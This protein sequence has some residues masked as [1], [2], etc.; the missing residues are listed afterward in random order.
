MPEDPDFVLVRHDGLVST[1]I[2]G[3][4]PD[5]LK[6]SRN[7]PGKLEGPLNNAYQVD[8]WLLTDLNAA[9]WEQVAADVASRLTDDV[10]EQAVRAL[11]QRWF[12][13]SGQQ[14][15]ADLKAR[16]AGLVAYVMRVYRLEAKDV[17]VHATDRD[18]LVT[19]LRA[20]DNSVDVTM[21]VAGD[22]T[23]YFRRRFLASET[24]EIRIYLHGGNDRVARTGPA[25]GPIL[26]RVIAGGGNDVIDDSQS[27]GT[28][29]WKDAGTVDMMRGAGSKVRGDVWVNPEPIKGAPWIEPRSFG[30]FTV[31][32]AIIGYNPDAGALLGYGFTRTAWGFRT[33]NAASSEQTI[34]GAFATSDVSGRVDYSGT[35]RRPASNVAFR[36]EA[37]GSGIERANFFGYG[38]D[39]PNETDRGRYRTQQ[40]VFSAAPS[41][42]IEQGRRFEAFVTPE[43]K[44]TRRRMRDP[45]RFSARPIPSV[46]ATS[47]NSRSGA[48]CGSIPGSVPRCMPPRI[49]P[50]ACRS[51]TRARTSRAS[52]SRRRV[53]SS[54]RRGTW[55]SQYGGFDGVVAAY[56]GN[57]RAHLALRAGGRKLVGDDYAW[58]DAAYIGSRNNRGFLSHRFAGDSSLFGTVALR[59]WIREVPVSIPVRFGVIAFADTGRVWYAGETSNTWHHSYGGGLMFQPLATPTTVYAALAHSKEGNRFYFGIGFPF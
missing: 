10:I 32:T 13:I 4:A 25:G 49:S 6:F 39:T 45:T 23:P 27:G 8:R 19:L 18:E 28:D 55:T 9:A 17:N 34:R 5:F 57:S 36:F 54:R 44:G 46:W 58:F 53:S 31:G 50:G 42:V 52:T 59:A 1:G 35:F 47:V 33:R 26:V 48:A 20:D 38:N 22:P 40:N 12:E 24:K 11:P 51:A 21:A 43:L 56:L 3:R 7:Y 29:V 30:H 37:F 41:L 16:R 15:I 14:T 2:R